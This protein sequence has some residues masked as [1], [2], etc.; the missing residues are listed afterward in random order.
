M[1][2]TIKN[3]KKILHIGPKKTKNGNSEEDDSN[4]KAK[5]QQKV[6]T[7]KVELTR[8]EIPGAKPRD[9]DSVTFTGNP[10]RVP[11][12]TEDV[13][14]NDIDCI[15]CE[16]CNKGMPNGN[17]I[18]LTN[19]LS[20]HYSCFHCDNCGADVSQQKYAYE[21]GCLMCEPCIKTRVRTNCYKC[22]MIIEMEDTKLIVD[23]K[24]F[25]ESC[26][27]CLVCS[28]QLDKIYGSKD[29]QYYCETCY[30]DKYG[31]KCAQC[32]KVI[33]GEGL[34]FGAESYHKDC[35]N[36]SQCS[37][38]LEQGSVHSIKQKPVCTACYELQFQE[39]CSACKLQV[40]EG[41]K[42]REERFH[43]ECFKCKTCS[44][45]LAE[46]KGD[47]LLTE[48]GLQCKDCVKVSMS[49]DI[50]AESVTENC[51]ACE[52]PIHVKNLVFD[53][54]KNW[55]Y[56]CFC[57]AQC[58]SALV[59]QK[60]YDKSGK[61]FCNNCFLAEHLPTC[62][63]CK[64]EIKGRS[65]VKMNATSGAVLT[66]HEDC[67]QCSEC[68]KG[69]SLDNV[70]FKDKLFCKSCYLDT[71]LNKCDK[72]IQPI[73]GVGYTFRGKFWHDTCFACDQCEKVFAEGK[74]RNLREEKLCDACFK[75]TTHND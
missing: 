63:N 56:K 21:R 50:E 3:I 64:V 19:G 16:G 4:G 25:H 31:K 45:P 10:V 68:R 32:A 38:T 59:N 12:A 60:Y 62:Y 11:I 14:D 53:G 54:E 26:F 23:G 27:S 46:R 8:E 70:V 39:T 15:K 24:E 33:L 69:I 67:L 37:S 22:V 6:L 2:K 66:W 48:N 57:C 34:R 28:A 74:F 7:T 71:M 44:I 52:L 61:L 73:T 5:M 40:S 65:G 13:G 47:F 35:F 51:T 41:L 36:C 20:W 55:H 17:E 72:C 58:N 30:V 49:E 18:S 9:Y 1:D 75:A 29:G 43:S 42:F